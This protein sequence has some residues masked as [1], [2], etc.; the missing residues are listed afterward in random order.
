MDENPLPLLYQSGYL[1]IKGYDKRF[2]T[3]TLG[4]PNREVKDG[5]I[6]YLV[7]FYTPKME[8][9]SLFSVE[10][11]VKDVETGDAES[12]M[13]RL[14]AFFAGGDYALM[15]NR[16]QYFHNAMYVFFTLLGLYV[17][18]ERHTTNGR[19]DILVQTKDYIYIFELK[20]DKSADIA[21]Q[22]IEEKGYAKPFA[23]DPRRLFKIGLNFST[24]K[25]LHRRL[26]SE[27]RRISI[28]QHPAFG[29]DKLLPPEGRKNTPAGLRKDRKH[30]PQD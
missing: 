9:K 17:E 10:R 14:E 30:G 1:T 23:H 18:V 5:F 3:F 11:F 2:G 28:R 6:K 12:F 7:P 29:V 22:Q 16:E 20:I 13:R 8:T 26:D 21:L 25:T 24:E 27:V 19:M 15:G 4:F